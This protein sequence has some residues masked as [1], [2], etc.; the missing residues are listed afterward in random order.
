MQRV[1]AEQLECSE[2]E[3]EQKF[4]ELTALLPGISERMHTIKADSLARI[5]ENPANIAERLTQ[6]KAIFPNANVQQMVLRD[7]DLLLSQSV[8]GVA[9]AASGLREILPK[10]VELDK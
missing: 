6:L 3:L 7:F 9:Q 1:A 10:G 2:E 5:V 8:D 4:Y